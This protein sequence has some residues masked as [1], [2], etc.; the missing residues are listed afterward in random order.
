MDAA[1]T[2]THKHTLLVKG[3]S[4]RDTNKM[5]YECEV[6]AF[7]KKRDIWKWIAGEIEREW[8]WKA[9]ENDK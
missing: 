8:E 1:G 7:I 3:K 4:V 5:R 9:I 6:W 2:H